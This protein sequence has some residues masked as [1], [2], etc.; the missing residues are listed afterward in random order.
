MLNMKVTLTGLRIYKTLHRPEALGHGVK[1][2]Q[3]R[4]PFSRDPFFFLNTVAAWVSE[5]HRSNVCIW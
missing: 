3:R 4:G 1:F 2:S 5:L